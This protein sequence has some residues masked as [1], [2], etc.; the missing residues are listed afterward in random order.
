LG[1]ALAA[2]LAEQARTFQN[3]DAERQ[4][5]DKIETSLQG[6][7]HVM[8]CPVWYKFSAAKA[9]NGVS[10]IL[11]SLLKCLSVYWISHSLR[12]ITASRASL[13]FGCFLLSNFFCVPVAEHRLPRP[14]NPAMTVMTLAKNQN[15]VG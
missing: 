4:T 3:L 8:Q 12:V 2:D 5:L 1:F 11:D 6:L 7:L 13:V 9:R 14:R 10:I 15:P